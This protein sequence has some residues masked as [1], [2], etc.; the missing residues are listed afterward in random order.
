MGSSPRICGLHEDV[1]EEAYSEGFT[2]AYLGPASIFLRQ[3]MKGTVHPRV[4]GVCPSC[5]NA[6]AAESRVHP[7][8]S[9]VCFRLW[10]GLPH[11]RGGL[12]FWCW[13]MGSNH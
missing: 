2:P 8:M 1:A 5:I 9:G 13:E 4:S 7:R 6:A 12:Y 11:F 3:T 10:W